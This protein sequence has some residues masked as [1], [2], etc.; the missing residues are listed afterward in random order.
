M[1]NIGRRG[2]R[3]PPRRWGDH[4]AL[5]PLRRAAD[6]QRRPAAGQGDLPVTRVDLSLQGREFIFLVER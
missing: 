1:F 5:P 3:R 6:C 2:C 4:R